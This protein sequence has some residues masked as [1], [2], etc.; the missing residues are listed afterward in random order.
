LAGT[1]KQNTFY[2]TT[3]I[4]PK[5]EGTKDTCAM[6]N[7]DELFNY[8]ASNDLMTLG[9]IHT[10]PNHECFL[11]SVD[12]HTHACYQLMLKE[13]VAVVIAPRYSPNFGIFTLTDTGLAVIS[14]CEKRGF[15]PHEKGL[16]TN[17]SH[18]DLKWGTSNPSFK[19]VDLRKK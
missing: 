8:Q 1:L 14:A 2:I 7:E 11:S 9:W 3:I 13:A 4:I 12:L 6:T 16:Y 10:H 17:C 5:Q 15:H 18:V 19:I